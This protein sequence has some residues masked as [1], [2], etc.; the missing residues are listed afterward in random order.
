M[1]PWVEW[2]VRYVWN[3][4]TTDMC[5][6]DSVNSTSAKRSEPRRKLCIAQF[7]QRHVA[8]ESVNIN[9]L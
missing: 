8:P 9:L 1:E 5:N 2:R 3:R 6:P 7:D 4:R